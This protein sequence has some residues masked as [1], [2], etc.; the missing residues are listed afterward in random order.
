MFDVLF[1][2]QDHQNYSKD[3]QDHPSGGGSPVVCWSPPYG[4]GDA[5]GA[6]IVLILGVVV[7]VVAMLVA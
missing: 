5:R 6:G 4:A 7:K 3:Y 2:I 1:D